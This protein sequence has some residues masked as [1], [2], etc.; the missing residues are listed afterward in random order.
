MRKSTARATSPEQ[1]RR[2]GRIGACTIAALIALPATGAGAVTAQP[3]PQA[4]DTLTV[5]SL[6]SAR[7][8]STTESDL[9]RRATKIVGRSGAAFSA[10]CGRGVIGV[11]G[12]RGLRAASSLKVAVALAAIGRTGMRPSTISSDSTMRAMIIQS[13]NTAANRMIDRAGGLR[14]V[15]RW[16]N[17]LGMTSSALRVAYGE[18][19]MSR[20]KK[21]TTAND[22]RL[23]ADKLRQLATTGKGTL[24]AQGFTRAQGEALL[25]LM[26]QTTHTGLFNGGTSA[27]VAHK[28]GWL[29][30]VEN[31]VAIVTLPGGRSCAMS[32]LTDGVG[33]SGAQSMG[34]QLMRSVVTPLANNVR[35]R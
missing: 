22:L 9:A 34:R 15:T 16:M 13:D 12:S 10:T 26:Q 29:P 3:A 11:N 30:G 4:T 23:L 24:A 31:D 35:S 1:S 28:S 27:V 8:L 5:Q 14:A 25:R 6:T 2:V 7:T 32:L 19:Y 33:V 18:D 20:T 17:G 21:V